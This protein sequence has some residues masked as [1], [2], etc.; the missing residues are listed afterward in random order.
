MLK[1]LDLKSCENLA[2]HTTHLAFDGKKKRKHAILADSV[3]KLTG[4]KAASV[5]P[6]LS[7]GEKIKLIGIAL[8]VSESSFKI[9]GERGYVRMPVDRRI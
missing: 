2:V 7:I 6:R 4:C 5:K 8:F 9:G 1:S 3:G